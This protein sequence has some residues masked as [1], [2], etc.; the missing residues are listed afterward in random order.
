MIGYATVGTNNL[1][2]ATA[3]YDKLFESINAKRVFV[4]EQGV[5]WSM[6]RISAGFGVFLPH[7][8]QPAT[9]GNGSMVA[10]AMLSREQVDNFYAK[11]ISLGATDEGQRDHNDRFYVNYF[12]DLEGNKLGVYYMTERRL[13]R[14]W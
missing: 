12:R 10:L 9:V 2:L 1:P 5:V 6:S 13:K 11:A 7:D 8:G 3:F 14:R 4:S